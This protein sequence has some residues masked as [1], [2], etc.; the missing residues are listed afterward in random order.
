[1]VLASA[2]TELRAL[3]VG[4]IWTLAMPSKKK[5]RIILF[6]STARLGDRTW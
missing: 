3:I 5:D 6:D 1:M 4:R 2:I